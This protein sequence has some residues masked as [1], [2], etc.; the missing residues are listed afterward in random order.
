MSSWTLRQQRRYDPHGNGP[1]NHSAA[2]RAVRQVK[3]HAWEFHDARHLVPMSY[4]PGVDGPPPNELESLRPSG[5]CCGLPG[6]WTRYRY[7][8]DRWK[9][10]APD[11]YVWTCPCGKG[12][13][14]A[15]R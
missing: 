1:Q 5:E 9:G 11:C 14:E 12:W 2:R 8:A 7:Y 15:Y 10:E 13:T 4:A 6:V 3:R